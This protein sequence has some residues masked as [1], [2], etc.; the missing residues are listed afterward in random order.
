MKLGDVFT[1][2]FRLFLVVVVLYS[3]RLWDVVFISIGDYGPFS[4]RVFIVGCV[5]YWSI[6]ELF[7]NALVYVMGPF[8]LIIILCCPFT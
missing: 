2:C 7:E 1:S 3:F 6:F 5:L 4:V 8:I